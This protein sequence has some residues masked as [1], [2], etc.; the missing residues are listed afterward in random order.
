MNLDHGYVFP[1]PAIVG[2]LVLLISGLFLLASFE[3]LPS[4]IG[5]GLAALGGYIAFT[6][7]G[8]EIDL[9]KN[10]FRE[11]TRYYGI[12]SGEWKDLKD[13]PFVSLLRNRYTQSTFS[14]SNRET[15]IS[16]HVYEVFI[17]SKNHRSKIFVK[18]F[19]DKEVAKQELNKFIES[20]GL[21]WV[22]YHPK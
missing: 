16:E 6:K 20:T 2:G 3:F 5:L 18:Q 17:L 9:D 10:Q 14:R 11:Y 8:L 12:I 15:S 21:E 1:V 4:I 7:T 19:S 13:Y 22:K